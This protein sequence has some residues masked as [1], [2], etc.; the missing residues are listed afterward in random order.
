MEP[1]LDP[2]LGTRK[3]LRVLLG[4]LGKFEYELQIR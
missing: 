1:G 3:L 4:Q 2:G